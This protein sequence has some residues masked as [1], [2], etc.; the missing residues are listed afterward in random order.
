MPAIR[1]SARRTLLKGAGS[2]PSEMS[3]VFGEAL[4]ECASE[5][6]GVLVTDRGGDHVDPQVAVSEKPGRLQHPLLA[7]EMTQAKGRRPLGQML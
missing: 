7:Q 6:G 5:T 3:A 2:V 1:S 4:L